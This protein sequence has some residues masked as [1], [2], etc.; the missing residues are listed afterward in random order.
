MSHAIIKSPWSILYI[1][2]KQLI[3]QITLGI[4]KKINL[5][6]VGYV[7]PVYLLIYEMRL[8]NHHLSMLLSEGHWII[9]DKNNVFFVVSLRQH[10]ELNYV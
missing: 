4:I 7:V 1:F 5:E 9:N 8:D 10:P 2:Y 3:I 6:V